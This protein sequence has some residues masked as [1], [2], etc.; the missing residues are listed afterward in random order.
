MSTRRRRNAVSYN[1][2]DVMMEALSGSEG[3]SLWVGASDGE[4]SEGD[5]ELICN[6]TN[7]GHFTAVSTGRGLVSASDSDEQE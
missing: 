2:D 1:G 3:T 4:V 6:S 7:G 5:G